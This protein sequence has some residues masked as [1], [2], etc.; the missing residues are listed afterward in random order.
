MS[1]GTNKMDSSEVYSMFESIKELIVKKEKQMEKSVEVTE[2]LKIEI[3]TSV[4]NA[5]TER[6]VKAAEEANKPSIV[7]HR[8]RHRIDIDIQ[9]NWF[10]FSW[11][12]LVFIIGASFWTIADQRETISEYKENDLK[13]RYVKMMGQTNEE[14]FTRLEHQFQYG[15]SI[16]FICKQVERY[17][18]LVKKEAEKIERMKNDYKDTEQ[19][20][21]EA[22]ALK[23]N[24]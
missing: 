3:D 1:T 15:D 24:K 7:E 4:I 16:K 20:Q 19:L 10:F 14:G 17:E 9:S 11:V 21:K 22:K 23:N 18:D 6:F 5:A 2:P 12:I 8:H 13:Y